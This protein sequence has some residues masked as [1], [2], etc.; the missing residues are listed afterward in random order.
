[1]LFGMVERGMGGAVMG[2]KGKLRTNPNIS[3]EGL[4]S[5]G[6]EAMWA[7][8]LT[9]EL[10]KK[11]V[12]CVS[13]PLCQVAAIDKSTGMTQSLSPSSHWDASI[14]SPRFRAR[15]F[16]SSLVVTKNPRIAITR[17]MTT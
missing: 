11:G 3:A 2:D 12:W 16:I 17:A 4:S 13:S 7:V 10:W 1:M 8:V 6:D 5:S 9:K 15:L 14:L